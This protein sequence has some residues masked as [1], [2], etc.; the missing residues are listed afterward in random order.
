MPAPILQTKLFA[1][2]LNPNWVDRPPLVRRLDHAAQTTTRLSLIAAQAGS[3]KSTLLSGWLAASHMPAAWLSL[4]AAD[5]DLLRF[6]TYVLAALRTVRPKLGQSLWLELQAPAPTAPLSNAAAQAVLTG[7]LNE[8]AAQPDR[9]VLILDD[10]HV[11]S[12]PAIHETVAYVIDHAPAT[13]QIIIASR[14]DPPLPLHRWRVRGQLLELRAADLRFTPDEAAIFLNDRM[15]LTLTRE[16]VLALEART[17]G[18]I[19]GL[20]LAAVSLQGRRDA[21]DFIQAFTGSQ[22]FVLDYLVEEVLSRQTFEVQTFLLHTAILDRLCGPLCDHVVD[23]AGSQAVLESLERQNL[24]LIALDEDRQW[25]RYHHLFGELLRARLQQQHPE[26]L[27]VMHRRAAEWFERQGQ[28]VE[29]LPHVLAARDFEHVADLMEQHFTTLMT[30]GELSILPRW[31]KLLPDDLAQRR[32]RLLVGQAW[33]HTFA[34]HVQLV[35]PLAEQAE[36]LVRAARDEPLARSVL[37]NLASIRSFVAQI[38]GDDE[39]ALQLAHEADR[40]LPPDEFI[41]RSLIP[42][43]LGR[44]YRAQGEMDK[45]LSHFEALVNVG[46]RAGIWTLSVAYYELAITCKL[47]GELNRA[48]ALYQAAIQQLT[49]HNARTMGAAASVDVGL[50]DLWREWNDLERA[51]TLAREAVDHMRPWSNPLNLVAAYTNLVRVLETCGDFDGAWAAWHE[52]DRVRQQF[53]MMP[54]LSSNLTVYGV[55]L[56]LATGRLAEAQQWV[57]DWLKRSAQPAALLT[58]ELEAIHAGRVLLALDRPHDALDVVSPYAED[59]ARQHRHGRWLQSLVIV[60]LAQQALHQTTAALATLE[61]ALHLA[62]PENY[63]RLL[64]DEGEKM[65]GLMLQFRRLLDQQPPEPRTRRLAAYTQRLLAL[66]PASAVETKIPTPQ[67]AVDNLIEPLSERELE[68]LRLLAEGLSNTQIADR[69][70]VAVGT[71]KTHVH[72]IYGKLGAQNRAQAVTRAAELRL[73]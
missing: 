71:V 6:W 70:V 28:V 45:C 23:R 30:R 55:R 39:R 29:A 7:L 24:F 59:A 40:L 65:R 43:T 15:G 13:L 46:Q 17:E 58:R 35:E 63:T 8:I 33:I 60:A 54:A 44:G 56:W 1:P 50:S 22:R 27:P 9:L 3:G 37:G 2:V 64:L 38:A 69:L 57:E 11:I 18:W 26:L 42:Y 19:A 34:G 48:N 21:H 62:E 16:D 12:N 67:P 49:E 72:N 25:S 47:R 73:L 20:Q 51:R 52:G 68:V 5:D 61:Q 32:P 66:F 53:A 10:Y 14:A 31:I 36:R 4:D 41:P